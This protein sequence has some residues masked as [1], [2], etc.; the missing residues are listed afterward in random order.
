MHNA[1]EANGE[2]KIKRNAFSLVSDIDIE[3]SM[4]FLMQSL[5]STI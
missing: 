5:L 3:E 4:R 2:V 1:K